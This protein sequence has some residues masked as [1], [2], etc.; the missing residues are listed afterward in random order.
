MHTDFHQFLY[1]KIILS[2]LESKMKNLSNTEFI[3]SEFKKLN[4]LFIKGKFD[5]V[6]EKTTKIIK[7]N[8]NQIPFYNLLAL[9][10]R[11]TNKLFTAEKVLNNAL[12][13]NPNDQ[14]VL[15]NLGATYRV[16]FEFKKSED[17]LKKVL[18]INPENINALVNYANLK[19]DTNQFNESIELYEKAYRIDNNNPII[20]INLS[21]VYQIV[22]KFEASKQMIERLLV[23]DENNVIAHKILSI[24]RKY[25]IKDEHQKKMI[26]IFNNKKFTDY[27]K[28]TLCFAISKSFDDQKNYKKS[29]EFFIKGNELQK[30]IHKN[31]S[32]NEE[33]KLFNKIKKIF[34]NTNFEK[35][36]NF[37]NNKKLIFIIGLPRSGTT[38]AHQI[39]A[40]HSKVYGADEMVILDQFMIRNIRNTNNKNINSLFE[41][42]NEKNNNELTNIIN[43][44]FD[45][46]SYI[47]TNKNIILD[48]NP[49][50]FQWLGFMKIL[51]PNCKIIH[52]KR[53]LKDTA[54]SL[55][56]NAFEINSIVWSNSQ[57]DIAKYIALYI[58][59]MGFWE[60]KFSNFIYN[61]SYE[62]LINNQK[63]EIKKVLSFCDLNWE[64]DCL[65]FNKKNNPIKTVSIV[66]ASQPIYKTSLQTYKNYYEYL[67]IF[68]K[69]EKLEKNS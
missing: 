1:L 52:C 51:F 46:I 58:D 50:N 65:N 40:A 68:K 43:N 16:L 56:K 10:Y 22:G 47:N 64:D 41:N 7:K 18:S 8:P 14:S 32:V 67:D 12:K 48:K 25:K 4:S 44:F 6:I 37:I 49:L 24:V 59:L 35:Y 3:K 69:I 53:N 33:V 11:E 31:Y 42:Y 13:I 28:A 15:V 2:I 5:L 9:S 63:E 38:L 39:L 62:K 29:S 54:L 19:R 55:F 57:D 34:T 21:G 23:L 66:Q 27:D 17:Y 60:K 20:L 45:K 26:N 61:L 36:P 30:K